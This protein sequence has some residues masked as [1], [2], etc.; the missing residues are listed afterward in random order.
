MDSSKNMLSAKWVERDEATVRVSLAD[1]CIC[2]LNN[3]ARVNGIKSKVMWAKH[4][5]KALALRNDYMSYTMADVPHNWDYKVVL[6][7]GQFNGFLVHY[8]IHM[9][10]D[11]GLGWAALQWVA[12]GSGPYK[13]QLERPWVPLVDVAA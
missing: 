5:R 8:N 4:K 13:N 9:D 12:C 7:K 2:L 11:L 3:P 10:P 1:K 6:P